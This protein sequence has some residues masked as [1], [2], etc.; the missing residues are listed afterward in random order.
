M[1]LQFFPS[2]EQD[3][4]WNVVLDGAPTGDV[5]FERD[6]APGRYFISLRT[7]S[8]NVMGAQMSYKNLEEVTKQL[9]FYYANCL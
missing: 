1:H 4:L 8:L 7:A 2:E 9:R 6:D 3:K 5:V